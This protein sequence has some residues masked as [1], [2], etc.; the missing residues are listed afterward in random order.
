MELVFCAAIRHHVVRVPITQDSLSELNEQFR[1]NLSLVENNGINVIVNPDL[2]IVTIF[3][4]SN[5]EWMWS[6]LEALAS[7]HH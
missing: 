1:A 7:M 6:R 3:E 2:A 4:D 5:G